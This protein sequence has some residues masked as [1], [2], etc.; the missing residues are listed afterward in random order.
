MTSSFGTLPDG[1]AV[2]GVRISAGRLRATILSWGATLQDLRF[3]PA[4]N[5]SDIPLVLGF[6]SIDDYLVHG[7]FHGATVGRVIN[8]IGGASALIDG[9]LHRLDSNSDGGHMLHG[10]SNGFGARNWRILDAGPAHASFGLTD[11]DGHMGFPGT[12]R[13]TCTYSIAET[14]GHAA[15]RVAFSAT[16]DAPTLVNF[17]HHSYFCLDDSR[18]IRKHHLRI[19]A[20]RYLPTDETALPTGEVAEPGLQLYTGQG[21]TGGG[22]SHGG[23]GNE[24]FAGIC[25]EPQSWPDAPNNASFPSID[26]APGERY[27]Q[28]SEFAFS[29]R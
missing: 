3:D 27:Q 24:P 6:D 22:S 25:L 26:L 7:R 23:H 28:V 18:D 5:R 4:D 1:D 15:L 20:D 11:P 14:D 13:A 10:G 8:R 2:T 12:V 17:G 29:Q 9:E 21:L 19:D 16:T